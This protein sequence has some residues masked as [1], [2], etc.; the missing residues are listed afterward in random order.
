MTTCDIFWV[1]VEAAVCALEEPGGPQ[2]DP[3]LPCFKISLNPPRHVGRELAA[4]KWYLAAGST[5]ISWEAQ[6]WEGG[7]AAMWS[8]R[9]ETAAVVSRHPLRFLGCKKE[10]DGSQ[11]EATPWII[12]PPRYQSGVRPP[13]PHSQSR[14]RETTRRCPST[15]TGRPGKP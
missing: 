6:C 10:R 7:C 2:E 14:R 3:L 1:G 15:T 11:E 8:C 9:G 13:A 4:S 12:P 5:L